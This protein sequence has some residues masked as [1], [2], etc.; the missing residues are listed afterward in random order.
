MHA[1]SIE[2]SSAKE[3]FIWLKIHLNISWC[4]AKHQWLKLY[5]YGTFS[6]CRISQRQTLRTPTR[7]YIQ[8]DVILVPPRYDI[9]SSS[10]RVLRHLLKFSSLIWW[11]ASTFIRK[12]KLLFLQA[13]PQ[14]T[15]SSCQTCI[16]VRFAACTCDSN[17]WIMLVRLLCVDEIHGQWVE[18]H[19]PQLWS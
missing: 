4:P 3:V 14:D 12:I 19:G 17:T 1:H 15:R 16:Q 6:C 13:S 11:T 2:I 9:Y 10:L 5:L 18:R 7:A 8:L